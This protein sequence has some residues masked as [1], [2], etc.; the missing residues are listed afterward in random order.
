MDLCSSNLIKSAYNIN[1][2]LL[3]IP[4]LPRERMEN[5]LLVADLMMLLNA[6]ADVPAA[7]VMLP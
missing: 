1:I 3:R 5:K 2:L 6:E 4:P 7:A